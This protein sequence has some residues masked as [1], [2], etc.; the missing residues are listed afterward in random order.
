MMVEAVMTTITPDELGAV[1]IPPALLR[2][3]GVLPQSPVMVEIS[4]TALIVRPQQSSGQ[5]VEVYTPER[6]AELLL[7]NT[8]DSADYLATVAVVRGMG[9]DPDAIPHG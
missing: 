8:V 6:K 2:Q 7:N 5:E 1:S 4:G 9:I 3:I